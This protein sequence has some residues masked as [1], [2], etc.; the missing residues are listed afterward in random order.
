MRTSPPFNLTSR[1]YVAY[2]NIRVRFGS[3]FCIFIFLKILGYSHVL[4]VESLECLRVD[5]I[6]ELDG[7]VGAPSRSGRRLLF[8]FLRSFGSFLGYL[9]RSF[10]FGLH[11]SK[12]GVGWV[13]IGWD[14]ESYF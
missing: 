10:Q 6:V 1:H 7:F 11:F 13:G 12:Q 8:R 5:E 14:G 2:S 4:F 3:V 9:F